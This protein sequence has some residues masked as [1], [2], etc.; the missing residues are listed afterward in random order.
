[1]VSVQFVFGAVTSGCLGGGNTTLGSVP[2]NPASTTIGQDASATS[3]AYYADK[4]ISY[5]IKNMTK[6]LCMTTPTLLSLAFHVNRD[7]ILFFF[8]HF[9]LG[10]PS[11]V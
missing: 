6:E 2:D 5:I 8:F 3:S 1:M 10:I 4:L 11:P 7:Y 9:V